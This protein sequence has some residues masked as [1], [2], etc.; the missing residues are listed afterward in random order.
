MRNGRNQA[1]W[2]ERVQGSWVHYFGTFDKF[3]AAASQLEFILEFNSY[4]FEGIQHAG[5]AELKRQ[6]LTNKYF[7]Y[8]P[9]FWTNRLDPVVPMAEHFYDALSTSAEFP[10]ELS[11]EKQ[12]VDVVLKGRGPRERVVFLRGFLA[13]LKAW[14][15]QAMMQ[16]GRF[17]F[18]FEWQGRL[19][20]AATA[21]G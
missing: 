1:L 8:L 10:S 19:K 17:P 13:H 18:T 2:S 9:D 20:E 16:Q 3:L 11:V 14:Q 12:A 7:A 15:G 4:V 6:Q 21:H 5:V